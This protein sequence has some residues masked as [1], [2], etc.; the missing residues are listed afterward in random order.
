VD[1]DGEKELG[2]YELYGFVWREG[3]ECHI[4]ITG[5]KPRGRHY[6]KEQ[7]EE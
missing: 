3:A 5:G 2:R 7:R 4:I 1:V 6:K